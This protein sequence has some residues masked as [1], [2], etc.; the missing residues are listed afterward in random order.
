MNIPIIF[1]RRKWSI[2]GAIIWPYLAISEVKPV[3]VN[4]AKWQPQSSSASLLPSYLKK[5]LDRDFA[6]RS[7]QQLKI[8]P[9]DIQNKGNTLSDLQKSIETAEG[10]LSLNCASVLVEKRAFLDLMANQIDLN[11]EEP[12]RV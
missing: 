4:T 8:N 11:K 6:L 9:V 10:E 12:T 2:C 3:S 1:M 5:S 7:R